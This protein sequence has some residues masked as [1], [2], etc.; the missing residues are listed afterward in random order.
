[1]LR[2]A[3]LLVF[4]TAALL[5]AQPSTLIRNALVLD[6]TGAPAVRASL[7]FSA[8]RILAIGNLRS[9]Q[10]ETV[11]D[12]SGLVLAPGFI[13]M[14]NHSDHLEVDSD[15]ASQ[16][17]QGLTTI[18]VGQDG[19]SSWPIADYL[20]ARRSAPAALNL[21]TLV[22]HATVRTQVM[23]KD[24]K[25]PARPEEIERMAALVD[26]AMQAGAVG[27]SSGLEYEVGSYSTTEELIAL[28]KAAAKHHGIYVS[29][30]RDEGDHAMDSFRE[31][32]R[33]GE[34]ARLPVEVSHIKLGTAAVWGKAA[35]VVRLVDAAHK[36][37]LDV[38][39]DCY[40]YDAWSSG[41]TVLVLDKQ[42]DNPASVAKG[43]ADVGGAENV[44]ITSC[45]A[46]PDFEGHTLAALAQ[47]RAVTPVALYS[48]IVKDGSAGV[49]CKAMK[50]DDIRLFYQQPWVMV[51]SDGGLR[52]RHPRG[53]GTYP[54][55][56]G[57]FVR[58][59][60]WLTLSEAVRKMTSAPAARLGLKDRGTLKPGAFADLVLF[61][62]ATVRD[63]AT[64][65]E[66]F[67][68]STGIEKVFVNGGL[69]WSQGK[70]TGLHPGRVLPKTP[71]ET[72]N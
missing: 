3:A 26:Q 24:Y 38:T 46:H 17:S 20:A 50:D 33:I 16:V 30:V 63:R 59:R 7:R 44:T 23:G 57:L 37:G 25:R 53:A 69:V 47:A 2:S 22:G 11:I 40:P 45:K 8:D 29:H 28:A 41:L 9:R 12:A 1:M 19:G 13:D 4:L 60:K 70:T 14:H 62:P 52:M 58:E 65:A 35:E 56:L 48:Q 18:L 6:G 54:R 42:Y 55:V 72:S 67:L 21:Q 32:I 5:P 39:A 10:G 71:S 64:F 36:R 61:D 27:L 66:P 31:E 34:E 15:A 51:G 49:V 68:L 43:L